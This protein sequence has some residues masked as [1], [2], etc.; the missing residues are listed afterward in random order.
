MMTMKKKEEAN[1]NTITTTTTEIDNS[2]TM[3]NTKERIRIEN[4]TEGLPQR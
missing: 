1:Y 2:S 4:I 3:I